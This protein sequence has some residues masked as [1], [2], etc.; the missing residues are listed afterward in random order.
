[1]GSTS[2]FGINSKVKPIRKGRKFRK[3]N[4]Q[5]PNGHDWWSD[6]CTE[7]ILREGKKKAYQKDRLK[8]KT[9]GKTRTQGGGTHVLFA[10]AGKSIH[11][12]IGTQKHW[13]QKDFQMQRVPG[14]GVNNPREKKNAKTVYR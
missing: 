12:E 9:A 5:P 7:K 6:Q 11:R 1:L 10:A 8:V 3:D 13:G 2:K 4:K 14:G